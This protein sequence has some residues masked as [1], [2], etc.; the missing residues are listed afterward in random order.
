MANA[1]ADHNVSSR[2]SHATR[3][4]IDRMHI[5]LECVSRIYTETRTECN[6][7]WIDRIDKESTIE[8]L[9]AGRR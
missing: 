2:E 3:F 9:C 1:S 7:T 5:S 4:E 8:K 6:E